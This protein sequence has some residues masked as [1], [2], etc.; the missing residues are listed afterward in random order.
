VG[1]RTHTRLRM[2]DFDYVLPEELIAQTPL[3]RRSSSRLMVVDRQRRPIEHRQFDDL[4][5]LLTPGDLLVV[6]DSKVLPARL[7]GRRQSGGRAEF[8][9]LRP[10]GDRGWR[11]LLRPARKLRVGEVMAIPNHRDPQAAPGEVTVLEQ[12]GDGEAT[13]A[14]DRQ[15]SNHLADYGRVPLPPYIHEV[16]QDD[17]RYQTVYSATEGSAAAPTA[18]LHFDES[19]FLRL[20]DRGIEVA[21]VTLHV[22]L[23]TF[24]PVTAEFADDHVIHQEW[25]SVSAETAA[26]IRDARANGSRI[27]AVGTTSARTLESLGN[28]GDPDSGAGYSGMTGIYITPGYRWTVVNAMITNFH[29]PKSSLLLMMSAFAGKD[30]LFEAYR[31]AIDAKYRFFSFGDAM[32]VT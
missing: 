13:I 6:N 26:Q 22:G 29:L 21:R 23:D 5:E 3:E 32:L 12:Q 2:A 1:D 4:P 7:I 10:E 11:C 14:L 18:G 31:Q 17:D 28:L 8:L 20:E 24:R 30:L 19:T 15:L 16:L 9:L 27:V 25:C